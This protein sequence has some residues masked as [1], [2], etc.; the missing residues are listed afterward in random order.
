MI[1]FLPLNCFTCITQNSTCISSGD[2]KVWKSCKICKWDDWWCHTINPTYIKYINRTIL[3]NFPRRSMKLGWLIVLKKT[4]LWV[5]NILLPWQL[6]LFQ[7]TPTWFQYVGDF[8]LEKRKT[9]PQTQANIF[10]CLLDHVSEAPFANMKV[11]RQRWPEIPL[12]LGRSGTQYIA[13]VIKL[14]SSNCGAP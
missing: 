11:E 9:R 6:T 14:L 4:H 13:M 2:N 8:Q 12:I 1:K 5:L 3:A 10:M 7:S